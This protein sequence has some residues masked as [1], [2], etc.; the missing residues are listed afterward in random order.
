M[1]V[2]AGEPVTPER[3]PTLSQNLVRAIDAVLYVAEPW[4]ESHAVGH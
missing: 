4:E 1:E 3:R 2:D